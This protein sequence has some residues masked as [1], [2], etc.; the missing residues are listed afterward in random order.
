MT[1]FKFAGNDI[2]GD[3]LNSNISRNGFFKKYKSKYEQLLLEND[4]TELVG[5][6]NTV[7]NQQNNSSDFVNFLFSLK[8]NRRVLE[9][10][11]NIDFAKELIKDD[12]MRAVFLLY[13]SALFYHIAELFKINGLD[14]PNNLYSTVLVQNLLL[15]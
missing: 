8:D 5:V 1:S 11:E 14:A 12:S 6:M 9:K 2:F 13:Y 10:S 15:C 3:G 7:I 4:L